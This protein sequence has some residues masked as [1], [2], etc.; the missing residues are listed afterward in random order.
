MHSKKEQ[1][2]LRQEA[3]ELVKA[4]RRLGKIISSR[5]IAKTVGISPETAR[6]ILMEFWPTRTAMNMKRPAD[7]TDED[8][9]RDTASEAYK[10]LVDARVAEVRAWKQKTAGTENYPAY[11]NLDERVPDP[12]KL[13]GHH[14]DSYYIDPCRYRSGEAQNPR[15]C[16]A[17]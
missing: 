4:R 2:R 14:P 15:T 7:V 6:R 12:M 3:I 8:V 10:Q 17:S 13:L 5:E 16:R 1:V 11:I 9:E